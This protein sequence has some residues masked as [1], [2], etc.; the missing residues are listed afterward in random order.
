MHLL[1]DQRALQAVW[2]VWTLTCHPTYAIAYS[3]MIKTWNEKKIPNLEVL[4]CSL[5]KVL[6]LF[7]FFLVDFLNFGP[8]WKRN[9]SRKVQQPDVVKDLCE[10]NT[11]YKS[12]QFTNKM[13]FTFFTVFS[14]KKITNTGGLFV[15]IFVTSCLYF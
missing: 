7:H 11:A 9:A 10:S 14:F 13:C 12:I 3:R 1:L 5:Q 4:W 8:F 6:T 2:K 15:F